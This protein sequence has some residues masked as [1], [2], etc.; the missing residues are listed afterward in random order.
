VVRDVCSRIV[1]MSRASPAMEEAMLDA[2]I[3]GEVYHL[4]RVCL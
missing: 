2:A 1:S 4:H 3:P